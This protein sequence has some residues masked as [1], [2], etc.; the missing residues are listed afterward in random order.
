[1]SKIKPLLLAATLLVAAPLP[2]Q[3]KPALPDAP[4]AI[5]NSP[6]PPEKVVEG[7]TPDRVAVVESCQ[8]NRFE[9]RVEID[10]ATKRTTRIKLCAN[11]G[12]SN[13]DWVK[14]LKAA[15]AQ[16]E[17]RNMPAEARQKLIEELRIEIARFA[18]ATPKP[19]P[20]AQGAAAFVTNPDAA[21]A[22]SGTT[23]RFETSKLPPLPAPKSA[24]T[25]IAAIRSK[26]QP[27]MRITLRCLE[28]G[29]TGAGGTCDFLEPRTILA[30]RAVEGVEGG[31]ILRF[32][33]R[34]E[35]RGEVALASM[36]AGQSIRVRLPVELCR[37][38]ANTNVEIELIGPKSAGVA[39]AR[40]GLFDLRC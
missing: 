21:A 38:V 31:G 36:Q 8:G 37:G 20:P 17:Q 30:I 40:L 14:T 32:R 34:G 5:S 28:Q 24:P 1:M 13:A 26:P 7:G 27:S 10:A 23:E 29:Q 4:T 19:T 33:R 15:V 35:V 25:A 9:S 12:A 3:Q 39:A 11:P 2:A 6:S 16:I 18:A 22:L